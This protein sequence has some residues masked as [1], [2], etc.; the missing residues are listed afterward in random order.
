MIFLKRPLNFRSP[1]DPITFWEWSW[2]WMVGIQVS[3]WED[4]FSGAM[5]VSG[6]VFLGAITITL[7]RSPLIR[8]LPSRDIPAVDGLDGWDHIS[9]KILQPQSWTARSWKAWWDWKTIRLSFLLGFG[10]FS[11]ANLLLNLFHSRVQGF[12]GPVILLMA[13]IPFPTAFGYAWNPCKSWDL[14][15][16]SLNRWATEKTLLLSIE[17]WLGY[18]DPYIYILAYLN[19]YMIG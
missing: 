17:S 8:S 12:L 6:S 7:I 14:N 11:G 3:I 15:Y 19:P 10:K 4:L 9:E 18:R 13:E 2:K 16:R 1:R 5:L